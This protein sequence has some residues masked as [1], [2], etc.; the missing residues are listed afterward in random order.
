[1]AIDSNSSDNEE[2]VCIAIKDQ[3]EDEY[4]KMTLISHVNKN[5]T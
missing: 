5:D 2:M 3:L 4:D 1:M